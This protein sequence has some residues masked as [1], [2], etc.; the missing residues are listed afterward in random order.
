MDPFSR[1]G[2]QIVKEAPPFDSFPEELVELAVERIGR[3]SGQEATVEL[4]EE[5]VRA[6][7][8]SFYLMCQAVASVSYPYSNETRLV[9]DATRDTI[10]YRMY[11]LFKRGE[12]DLCLGAVQQSFKL[13]KLEDGGKLGNTEVPKDDLLRI[14][15]RVLREDG[16]KVVDDRTLPL[17]TPKY[18]LRWTDFGP[19]LR[20]QKT[21][22]T[23]LYIVDGW[24]VIT[25]RELWRFFADHVVAI[26]EEYIAS[27]CEQFSEHGAPP[28]V[29]TEVGERISKLIPEEKKAREFATAARGPLNPEA[30][31]PCVLNTLNGVGSG[32]RN[33]AITVLLTSFLSRARAPT[34]SGKADRKIADHI[35]DVSVIENE[36]M[37]F[38]IEAAD[39]CRPPFF[40]DQ[41]QEKANVY[42]HM[43]FGMAT[44]P[45]MGASGSSKWY[46]TPNCNKIQTSAPHLC[47][48]DELCSRI[49]NPL[50]YYYRKSRDQ[51]GYGGA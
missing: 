34:P 7:V 4:N 5:A 29:L 32:G 9:T 26:T 15:D 3:R 11:D 41:P 10:R 51:A 8:L 1:E 47:T 40:R 13:N 22:L 31:P 17:Y 43:G 33:Y 36:I 2:K 23:K 25:P 28:G 46:S 42:Y 20:H 21:S 45:S 24:A 37:P 30:F 19:L 18:A 49:T 14:R 44:T 48:P 50:T 16:V 6:E 35:E 27:L 39:K 12:E 38:I